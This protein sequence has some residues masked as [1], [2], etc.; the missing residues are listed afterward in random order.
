MAACE[1]LGV[2]KKC[3]LS[4]TFCDCNVK[5]ITSDIE[6]ADKPD[7]DGW[8]HSITTPLYNPKAERESIQRTID[9]IKNSDMTF[10]TDPSFAESRNGTLNGG[11]NRT[12]DFSTVTMFEKAIAEFFGAP[13]A[14]ATDSCTHALELCMRYEGYENIYVPKHTYLSVPMLAE[15]LAIDLHWR[16]EKWK[17]YYAIHDNIFD[18]AVLWRKNSYNEIKVE[19]GKYYDCNED[20]EL[21]KFVC[22]SFQKQKH[23]SLG[24][25]GIILLDNEE[26]AKRLRK[27]RYDGRD[28]ETPWREQNINEYGF[29]YYCTPELATEGL[30]KLPEAIA[31][32]PRQWVYTD[33]NDLTKM[34]IFKNTL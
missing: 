3:N 30:R 20:V 25:A 24:R 16:N 6:M 12:P 32:P 4:S 31:T 23:L 27:W 10:I 26:A 5:Y 34:K 28:P 22:I 14:V 1:N 29:H 17:D 33:W 13:Y 15:K 19:A 7:K 21:I 8:Y 9:N 18:A 2:C 11:S